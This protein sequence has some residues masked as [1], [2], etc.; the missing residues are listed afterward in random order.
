MA[1]TAEPHQAYLPS[2]TLKPHMGPL[3]PP[4][5]LQQTGLQVPP[6]PKLTPTSAPLLGQGS[7]RGAPPT[8]LVPFPSLL[9]SPYSMPALPPLVLEIRIQEDKVPTLQKLRA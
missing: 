5:Q 7:P 2:I 6:G 9:S 4:T 3:T 8:N 1:P